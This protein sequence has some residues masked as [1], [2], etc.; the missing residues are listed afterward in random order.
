M[1]TVNES[2][3]CQIDGFESLVLSRYIARL[4]QYGDSDDTDTVEFAQDSI[5]LLRHVIRGVENDIRDQSVVDI[6]R[7]LQK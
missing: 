3:I 7:S 4:E 2:I 6:I 1:S 5:S